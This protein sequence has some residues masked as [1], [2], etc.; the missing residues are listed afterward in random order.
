VEPV[1]VLRPV[2]RMSPSAPTA[3]LPPPA[4]PPKPAKPAKPA[5]VAKVV[6]PSPVLQVLQGVLKSKQG[7]A[8][9]LI[10]AEIFG[11]PPGKRGSVRGQNRPKIG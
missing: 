11:E 3:P 7:P 9:A 5:A 6:P 8:A 2:E 10:L 1:P 4:P